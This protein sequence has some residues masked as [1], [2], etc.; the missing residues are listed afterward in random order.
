MQRP[1][2]MKLGQAGREPATRADEAETGVMRCSPRRAGVS[3]PPPGSWAGPPPGPPEG[4]LTPDFRLPA[5]E[6]A[7][8]YC[9]EPPSLWEFGGSPSRRCQAGL[10]C[11][12]SSLQLSLPPSPP[13]CMG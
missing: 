3:L 12:W 6:G 1:E 8:L 4:A 9:L 10:H 7:G 5:P 11:L 2:K 13:S